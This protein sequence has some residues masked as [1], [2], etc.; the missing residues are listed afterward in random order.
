M[1]LQLLFLS[2]LLPTIMFAQVTL[3]EK[4]GY[5]KNDK[6][7][8]I[9][10]DDLGVSHSENAASI[11]AL[12][13]GSVISASIM[14]PCPWFPEIAAYAASHPKADFGLHMTLT[15]EWKNYKWPTAAAKSDVP[16]LTNQYHFMYSAVDSVTSISNATEV[17]AELRAQIERAKQFGIDIT[18]LDSHMGT[19]YAKPDYVN[20]LRKL[21]KEYKI[22]VM[23]N[24]QI[25]SLNGITANGDDVVIDS[26]YVESPT[27]YKN[28]ANAFYTNL[29][30]N[31]KPGV[32]LVILHAAFDDAEM[33]AVTTGH[34]DYGAAWRQADYNF[35]TSNT[36]KKL[37]ADNH[38]HVITW[39][40]IRD[41]VV[42]K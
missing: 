40:E 5:Q 14:V 42:R 4:L 23:L 15:S 12:E 16:T 10:A 32:S 27:D 19:I 25:L 24:G 35:F 26:I 38:I 17:E 7:L 3:Q 37:L 2:F 9:H 34:P 13:H 30:N 18:H 8:I 31:V 20:V 6:L 21:G 22:P 1:K 41:K 11:S 28:G 33:Q 36:C 39:R 29:L